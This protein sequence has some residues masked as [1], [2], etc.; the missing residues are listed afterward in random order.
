MDPGSSKDVTAGPSEKDSSSQPEKTSPTSKKKNK[1]KKKKGQKNPNE[2]E[3]SDTKLE[4]VVKNESEESEKNLDTSVNEE[5]T[6]KNDLSKKPSKNVSKNLSEDTQLPKNIDEKL[7]EESDKVET[8]PAEPQQNEPEPAADLKLQSFDKNIPTTGEIQ[9]S[10]KNASKR[11]TDQLVSEMIDE[12]KKKAK[13]KQYKVLKSDK[14]IEGP[15]HNPDQCEACDSSKCHFLK[16]NNVESVPGTS[17]IKKPEE[18]TESSSVKKEDSKQEKAKAQSDAEVIL[19]NV[20]PGVEVPQHFCCLHRIDQTDN[21]EEE[22]EEE[23]EVCCNGLLC[24]FSCGGKRVCS[25]PYPEEPTNVKDDEKTIFG[26]YCCVHKAEGEEMKPK[27]NKSEEIHEI[28]KWKAKRKLKCCKGELCNNMCCGGANCELKR[29]EPHYKQ[30]YTRLR[31]ERIV[32][33]F[34]FF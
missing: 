10:I 17:E 24:N 26:E 22:V 4:P 29:I 31:R 12:Y 32:R 2:P 18:N 6:K 11:V 8:K 27:Q 16:E 23:E 3:S 1:K 7:N 19:I 20:G 33:F 9:E 34:F 5:L 13:Q 28:T 25:F 14:E 15:K 21:N 30:W